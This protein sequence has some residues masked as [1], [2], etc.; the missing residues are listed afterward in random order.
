[1]FLIFLSAIY[2]HQDSLLNLGEHLKTV[3]QNKVHPSSYISHITINS[4]FLS[5]RFL[6]S[7]F[8]ERNNFSWHK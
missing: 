1:M 6:P 3:L 7:L 5:L 8:D 4:F 2:K